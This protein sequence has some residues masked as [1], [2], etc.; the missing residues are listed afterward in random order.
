M[1]L[2][3]CIA[4]LLLTLTCVIAV[5]ISKESVT[6][7]Y[8]ASNVV[9]PAGVSVV[10]DV[11]SKTGGKTKGTW[12]QTDYLGNTYAGDVDGL[13]ID[14]NNAWISGVLTDAGAEDGLY[15]GGR[16]I[17][18]LT[19]GGVGGTDST[20][21]AWVQDSFVASSTPYDCNDS[22]LRAFVDAQQA[23]PGLG[24]DLIVNT[25]GIEIR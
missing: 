7:N 6:G 5:R 16:F 17:L 15:I 4:C 13:F 14:G 22:A 11:K 18:R 20:T 24:G 10:V 12:V 8:H 21:N 9:S 2:Y 19:D 3:A 23:G 25:G 1:K